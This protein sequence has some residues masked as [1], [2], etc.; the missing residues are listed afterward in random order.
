MALDATKIDLNSTCRDKAIQVS[1]DM[2]KLVQSASQ[3][4]AAE[5]AVYQTHI[6]A[7]KTALTAAG[8]A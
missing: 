1:L 5:L 8:A 6:T 7:L 4:T 2:Q 3:I